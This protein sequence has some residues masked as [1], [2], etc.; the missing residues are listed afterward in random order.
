M[1]QSA[2]FLTR[3]LTGIKSRDTVVKNVIFPP[4]TA[5]FLRILPLESHNESAIRMEVY[6]CAGIVNYSGYGNTSAKYKKY[7][8]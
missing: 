5:R 4:I 1:C 3:F 6:G 7:K 8:K 2:S